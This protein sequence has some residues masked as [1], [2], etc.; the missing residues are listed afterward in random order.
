MVNKRKNVEKQAPSKLKTSAIIPAKKLFWLPAILWTVCIALI[1]YFLNK[2]SD[3]LWKVQDLNL[4]LYTPLYFKQQ[5]VVPGGMLTY[6]GTYFTQYFYH[7]WMGVLMLCGWWG[8]LMWIIKRTFN[9]PAKWA[10]LML[11]PIALLLITDVDLGYWVFYLKLRGHFFV[12]TI[13]TTLA[14]TLVWLYRLIPVRYYLRTLFILIAAIAFYPLLG[15]YALLAVAL[16]GIISWRLEDW[17]NGQK[18]LATILAIVC[19][20]FVPMIYYR[21]VYYQTSFDN[22]WWTALP[23]FRTDREHVAYYIPYYLLAAYFVVLS[24]T[25]RANRDGDVTKKLRFVL[26]QCLQVALIIALTWHFWYKDANFH[27]ELAMLHCIEQ[28]DWEGALS[29]AAQQEEEPTRAIVLMKNLSLFRLGRQGDEMYRYKTGSASFNAPFQARL[30]QVVGRMLYYNYGKLNFCYRWC[31]EDGV[32]YGWRVEFY[33]YLIQCAIINGEKQVAQKYINI[34][35][36]TK[37][38]A[39]WAQEQEDLMNNWETAKEDKRF[40]PIIQLMSYRDELASDNAFVE[41]FL[42]YQFAYSDGGTPLYQEQTL[43][44]ALQMKQIELF[45]PHFFNYANLHKGERMPRHYQEAAFLY[46]TLEHKVDISHMP[47]D[48][49]V[50]QDYRE[51]MELA[52]RCKGMT[53]EQMKPIFYPRFGHTFYYDYYLIRKQKSY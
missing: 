47:F 22:M 43:L 28:Q 38:Y 49:Q 52:Q 17:K 51:F 42:L 33:R 44:S 40:A 53:E 13:G 8:L 30:I 48:K 5:M 27:R 35:K 12:A 45:W 3:F 32:E 1:F 20:L 15:F 31:L 18:G 4:F 16:M 10:S 23:L 25:Y 9:I 50:I 37:Y 2:E 39:D 24:L 46:G 7:T 11:Y 21:T 36:Q 34:L 19:I 41:T 14:I 26:C 29:E 6:L